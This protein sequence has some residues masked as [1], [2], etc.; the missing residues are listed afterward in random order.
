MDA[1]DIVCRFGGCI[2]ILYV[3]NMCNIVSIMCMHFSI[4]ILICMYIYIYIF[5]KHD[6]ICIYIYIYEQCK[7]T[8]LLVIIIYIYF[9]G[10]L[11]TIPYDS[12][13]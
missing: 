2:Y 1:V 4:C 8:L 6:I 10:L 13:V 5:N 3:Y 12:V 9:F 11:R 7:T